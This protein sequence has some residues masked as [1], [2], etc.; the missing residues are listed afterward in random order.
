MDRRPFRRYFIDRSRFVRSSINWMS[1]D[2]LLKT[3]YPL[4]VF[5]RPMCLYR[6]SMEV[7]C[8]T[9]QRTSESL[10]IKKVKIKGLLWI[11]HLPNCLLQRQY[12]HCKVIYAPTTFWNSLLGI[13]FVPNNFALNLFYRPHKN[14]FLEDLLWPEVLFRIYFGTR[15]FW[16]AFMNR[17]YFESFL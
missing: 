7:I 4:K 9:D 16:G 2:G 17:I 1:F 12:S 5:Y 13:F 11:K 8:S 3:R 6:F 10:K 14:I 15:T